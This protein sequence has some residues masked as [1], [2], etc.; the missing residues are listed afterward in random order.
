MISH[1]DPFTF[2]LV[3]RKPVQCANDDEWFAWYLDVEK[4]RRVAIT[5]I[6]VA[7]VPGEVTVSTVFTSLDLTPEHGCLFE[8]EVFGGE[9]DRNVWRCRTWEEAERQHKQVT[10][11][12]RG[13]IGDGNDLRHPDD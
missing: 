8:T 11:I 13:S 12:V 7:R 2:K 3:D 4:N 10:A 6:Q 5:H 9:Y 1:L